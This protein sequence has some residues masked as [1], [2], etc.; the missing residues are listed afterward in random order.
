MNERASHLPKD[1]VDRLDRIRHG[2]PNGDKRGYAAKRN[3]ITSQ[4]LAA[5]VADR[6]AENVARKPQP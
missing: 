3:Q 2:M 1:P 4:R 6:I 5:F